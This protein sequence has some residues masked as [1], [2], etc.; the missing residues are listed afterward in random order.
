MTHE[1]N[2][3]GNA[4]E[5]VANSDMD[6]TMTESNVISLDAFSSRTSE[7]QKGNTFEEEAKIAAIRKRK[8]EEDRAKNNASVVRDLRNGRGSYGRK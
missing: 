7:K 4:N 5:N 8:Q 2:K 3:T 6:K 1:R